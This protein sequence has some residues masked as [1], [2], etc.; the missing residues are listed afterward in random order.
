MH[1]RRGK[2]E[3]TAMFNEIN[4]TD[5]DKLLACFRA[6]KGFIPMLFMGDE[7]NTGTWMLCKMTSF[8]EREPNGAGVFLLSVL[9]RNTNDTEKRTQVAYSVDCP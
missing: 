4:E 2:R 7:D 3:F 5:R 6:G 8:V 1:V 9:W